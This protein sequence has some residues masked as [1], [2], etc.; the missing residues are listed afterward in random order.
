[1]NWKGLRRSAGPLYSQRNQ[2][3]LCQLRW[4]A[5]RQQGRAAPADDDPLIRAGP[6]SSLRMNVGSLHHTAVKM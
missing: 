1:M 6:N 3:N 4:E 2:E 5:D